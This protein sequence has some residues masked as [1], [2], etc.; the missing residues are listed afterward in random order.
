VS[1]GPTPA[2]SAIIPRHYGTGYTMADFTQNV[3]NIY[4]T[5]SF[6]PSPKL[7]LTATVAYNR[8][9]STYGDVLFDEAEIRSR[10]V[11]P[12]HPTG[13]LAN[14]DFD[15][16]AMP[17]YSD[18]DFGLVQLLLGFEYK[19]RRGMAWTGDAEIRDLT[20]K[21][22]GYIFGDESGSMYIVRTGVRV[23]L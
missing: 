12:E 22:G 6:L 10:L 2:D 7:S 9:K 4:V 19:F 11:N 1:V 16:T 15:F 21:V 20:D 5:A 13:D 3:H 17:L 18:L 14:Q 8:S 23:D